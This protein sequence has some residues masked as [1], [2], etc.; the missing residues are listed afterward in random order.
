MSSWSFC[1][2]FALLATRPYFRGGANSITPTAFC[3]FSQLPATPRLTLCTLPHLPPHRV[4]GF[5]D[6]SVANP[7]PLPW[8][9]NPHSSH[10]FSNPTTLFPFVPLVYLLRGYRVSSDV[11]KR[12]DWAITL[13]YGLVLV[14]LGYQAWNQ[15]WLFDQSVLDWLDW[16]RTSW[17]N[18]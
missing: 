17:L 2:A 7:P 3:P 18:A 1:C 9:H 6:L 10:I 15:G 12:V 8:P 4:L 5:S 13:F 16:W 14:L 11:G